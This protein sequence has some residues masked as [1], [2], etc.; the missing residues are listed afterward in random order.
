MTVENLL[1]SLV[2]CI[3]TGSQC[4]TLVTNS[5]TKEKSTFKKK[6]NSLGI[7]LS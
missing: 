3:L 7:E 4:S 2:A 5:A 1:E 6:K